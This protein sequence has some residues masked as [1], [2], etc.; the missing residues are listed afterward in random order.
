[1]LNN[2]LDN[3]CRDNYYA[4]MSF[5][6]E[7]EKVHSR[8]NLMLEQSLKRWDISCPQYRLLEILS[9]GE[10]Y[11]PK[12]LADALDIDV[13]ASTR[14]IDRLEKKL[15]INKV[16]CEDDRRVCFISIVENFRNDLKLIIEHQ[17]RVEDV[18]FE[19]ISQEHRSSFKKA[20][21][22]LAQLKKYRSGESGLSVIF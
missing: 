20:V 1:M 13:A 18:F 16:R 4:C 11:R 2:C 21:G 15:M 6:V 3:N 19:G 8:F 10:K 22:E 17:Q 12:D 7:F 9:S 5:L 14:L